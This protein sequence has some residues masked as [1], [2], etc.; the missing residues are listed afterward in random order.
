LFRSIKTTA[1]HRVSSVIVRARTNAR[2]YRG[3]RRPVFAH[4]SL[5]GGG[6]GSGDSGDSDSGDPPGPSHHP[7]P[8]KLSQPFR[9]ES[10][11]TSYR[12]R[13]SRAFGCWLMPHGERSGWRWSV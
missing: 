3:A 9:K 11:S 6:G 7:A 13:F 2:A 5:D 10:N 12:R 1:C 8:L 4:S